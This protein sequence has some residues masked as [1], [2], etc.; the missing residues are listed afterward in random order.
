MPSTTALAPRQAHL[1]QAPAPLLAPRNPPIHNRLDVPL[2]PLPKVLEHG[3]PPREHNVLV[4]I[5][6][7]VDGGGLDDRVNHFGQGGEEV[8][9]VDFGVEEDLGSEETLVPDVEVVFLQITVWL[10]AERMGRT[11]SQEC[12]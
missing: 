10:A 7:D 4:Q 3:R 6:P 1:H 12:V 8:G 2:Q 5:P 9:R 11:I